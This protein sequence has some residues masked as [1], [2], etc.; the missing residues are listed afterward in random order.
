MRSQYTWLRAGLAGGVLTRSSMPPL[1]R[2]TTEKKLGYSVLKCDQ[3]VVPVHQ[4]SAPCCRLMSARNVRR[5]SR[6]RKC[7]GCWP[8]LTSKSVRSGTWTR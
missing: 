8:S 6:C 2:W 4:V 1:R 5:G 3:I 7:T